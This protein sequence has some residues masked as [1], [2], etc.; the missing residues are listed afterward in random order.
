VHGVNEENVKRT[1]AGAH[2]VHGR[3]AI[4]FCL[5]LAYVQNGWLL[6]YGLL[7]RKFYRINKLRQQSSRNKT[8]RSHERSNS[9]DIMAP[10]VINSPKMFLEMA[11]N[12]SRHKDIVRVLLCCSRTLQYTKVLQSIDFGNSTH[13][14]YIIFQW[15]FRCTYKVK[16]WINNFSDRSCTNYNRR[17]PVRLSPVS[18]NN[19]ELAC[20]TKLRLT[21]FC[22]RI[23]VLLMMQKMLVITM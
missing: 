23:Y 22:T 3:R 19:V 18:K 17:M 11:T 14:H 8:K 10:G 13:S 20:S 7:F 21:I 6:I 12:I 16:R 1:G 4:K 5:N 2:C 15:L 9:P